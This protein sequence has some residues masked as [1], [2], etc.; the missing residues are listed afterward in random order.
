[1]QVNVAEAKA[2]LS[3][4]VQA[5]IDGED[6]VIAR[7]GTALVRLVPVQPPARR[8]LGSMPIEVPDELFDPLT[9]DDLVG[10][11]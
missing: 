5:A 8:R 7:A 2:Q 3:R 1:M 11:V 6:V 10:W 9:E 4:L